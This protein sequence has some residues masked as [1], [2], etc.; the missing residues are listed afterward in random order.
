MIRPLDIQIV[1][2]PDSKQQET[3]SG[4]LVYSDDADQIQ[5]GI[6]RSV[7]PAVHA[8]S[9]G[10]RIL[11]EQY[12]GNRINDAGAECLV[13]SLFDVLAVIE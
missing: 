1:V 4:L 9:I 12:A 8:V 13:L 10:D 6:V 3:E 7:G 2:V 11:Y 5:T